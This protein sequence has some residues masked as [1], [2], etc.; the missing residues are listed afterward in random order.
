MRPEDVADAIV[1]ALTRPD[2]MTIEELVLR[3]FRDGR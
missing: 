3:P 1:F 2:G